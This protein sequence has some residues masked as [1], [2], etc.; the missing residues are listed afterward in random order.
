MHWFL[1][2]ICPGCV[3][4]WLGGNNSHVEHLGLCRRQDMSPRGGKFLVRHF[5]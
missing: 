2:I 1:Q 3:I 4:V 5:D